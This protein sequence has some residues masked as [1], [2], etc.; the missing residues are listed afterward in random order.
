MGIGPL[1][2]MEPIAG[3]L[4][5]I[6]EFGNHHHLDRMV[7]RQVIADSHTDFAAFAT[8]N[9]NERC[10]CSVVVKN[11]VGFRAKLRTETARCFATDALIN[12]R[13]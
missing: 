5:L 7:L 8:V 13:D 1:I 9:R 4:E 3:Q 2:R 6:L 10:F 12:M 11:G